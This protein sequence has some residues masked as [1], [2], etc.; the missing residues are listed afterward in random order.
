[1][2]QRLT[3]AERRVLHY[4]RKFVAADAEPGVKS[5]RWKLK[6]IRAVRDYRAEQR[7]ERAERAVDGARRVA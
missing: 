3:E 6:L 2:T 1:M 4:A 5:L 7:A